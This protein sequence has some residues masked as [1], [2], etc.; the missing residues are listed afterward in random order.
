[1]KKQIK[2]AKKYYVDKNGNV[3]KIKSDGTF[4]TL[5][6]YLNPHNWYLY[7]GITFDDGTRLTKRVH[8]LVL[9]TFVERPEDMNMVNHKNGIKNDNRLSN[10]EW[11][12][13]SLNMIHAY[14]HGLW[15]PIKR[16][17]HSVFVDI[18]DYDNNIIHEDI[19]SREASSRIGCS[20]STISRALNKY[21]GKIQSRKLLIRRSKKCVTTIQ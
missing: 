3:Y 4:R 19:S 7:I 14:E 21:D 20:L 18:L 5:K 16:Q 9:Q 15:V 17:K 6:Q 1:M 12:N 10:L 13:D 11:S 8:K 2:D